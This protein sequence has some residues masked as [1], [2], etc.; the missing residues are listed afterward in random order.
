VVLDSVSNRV[1]KSGRLVR[2]VTRGK[3]DVEDIGGFLDG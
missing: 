1:H 2:F 3:S